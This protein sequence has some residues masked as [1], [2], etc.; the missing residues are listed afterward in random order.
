MEVA[1]QRVD[2]EAEL[3]RLREFDRKVF[4]AA[5]VFPSS[6][7]RECEVYWLLVD[8][9]RAGCCAFQQEPE[10][11]LAIAT[12]GLLPAWQGMGL[13]R[14]MKTWQLAFARRYGYRRIVTECRA[15]NVRMIRLNESFGFQ[16]TETTPA[17]YLN[18]EE[19]GVRMEL[20]L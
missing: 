5:D 20:A 17:H 16:I 11:V 8:G 14:L 15:G 1:F 18:P 4:P 6:Y 3:R 9:K 10:N 13:G 7:W 12:T 19:A 2:V